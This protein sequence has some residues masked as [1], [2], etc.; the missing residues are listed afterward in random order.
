MLVVMLSSEMERVWPEFEGRIL[1]VL[2]AVLVVLWRVSSC[3]F[4]VE[5]GRRERWVWLCFECI[6]QWKWKRLIV[7]WRKK[8]GCIEVCVVLINT[9]EMKTLIELCCR[10]GS[11]MY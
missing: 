9:K 8:V 3:C 5:K 11:F 4:M 6:A 2:L 1:L 10:S 7:L